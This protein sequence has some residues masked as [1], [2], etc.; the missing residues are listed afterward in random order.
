MAF[1][2]NQISARLTR[3]SDEALSAFA[4]QHMSNYSIMSLVA[5]ELS[6]RKEI[7]D[8][9]ALKMAG[10]PPPVNEQVVA[11]LSRG[12]APMQ[13]GAGS[14]GPA[15]L[16]E[17]QG[18]ARLPM[19]TEF[20][21][22]GGIV[23]YADGGVARFNGDTGSDVPPIESAATQGELIERARRRRLEAERQAGDW[24]PTEA[25]VRGRTIKS[26]LPF[27][28]NVAAEAIGFTGGAAPVESSGPPVSQRTLDARDAR[29]MQP[30]QPAPSPAPAPARAASRPASGIAQLAAPRAPAVDPRQQAME[31]ARYF[32]DQIKPRDTE[33]GAKKLEEIEAKS[34]AAREKA[35]KEY[36]AALPKDQIG[37]EAEARY[38]KEAEAEPERRKE[39]FYMAMVEAGLGMMASRSPY[40]L[41][42]IGEGAMRG[43]GSYK[44]AMKELDSLARSR[45]EALDSIS[46][47]RRAEQM[48]NAKEAYEYAQTA[49]SNANK[50]AKEM[51][52]FVQG[53]KDLD[54]Q[55]KMNIMK[56]I[57]A[58]FNADARLATELR[59]RERVAGMQL[60]A[61]TDSIDAQILAAHKAG[62]AGEVQ[63]LLAL[64]QSMNTRGALTDA[65]ENAIVAKFFDRRPI[66]ETVYSAD[67]TYRQAVLAAAARGETP[68][69]PTQEQIRA[70][71]AP[72]VQP[73]S[74]TPVGQ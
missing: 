42:G 8:A 6:R 44:N 24:A 62:N 53:R 65:Q 31:D 70:S 67:P 68:P 71:R 26:M 15:A 33:T 10:T 13:G 49:D 39:A 59:S 16:P 2:F 72:R 30:A 48:G 32:F 43:V 66:A 36:L 11:A 69:M 41:Q 54:D 27:P 45:N 4:R 21:A 73:G 20:A 50:F 9:S 56:S 19:Q 12:Q 51:F 14:T 61:R 60:S 17:N 5:N 55:D 29:A 28:L 40:A 37:A 74:I 22:E 63:K 25:D 34:V 47:A 58:D 64:K 46:K 38:K 35:R 3:L 7:R 57:Y 18:I 1:D 52:N 23:G